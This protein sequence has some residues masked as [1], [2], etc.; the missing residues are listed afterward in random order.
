MNLTLN[1]TDL[2]RSESLLD[3]AWVAASDGRRLEVINPATGDTIGQVPDCSAEDGRA[4]VDAAQRAFGLF[5]H[6]VAR[7]RAAL[8]MRWHALVLANAEDLARLMSLEQ[9][10]PLAESR[11]EVAYGASYISWFAEEAKR[12]GGDIIPEQHANHRLLVIKQPVGVVAAITPWNFPM[13]MLARK[14]APAIAAG[15][16]VVC[17]P[18]EDTPLT[19][20]AMAALLQE[21][22]A[23]AGLVN[24][25]TTSRERA[26]GLAD[27]WL[28]DFRVRKISFTGSTPVGKHL[29]RQSADTL[30][31]L[32]LE[33]GG[34]APFIVFEDADL[35]AAVAGL[36]V[37][38]FRNAGQTCICPNRVYVHQGVYERFIDKLAARVGSLTIGPATSGAEIGPLINARA[39]DKV[40]SHLQDALGRGAKIVVGGGRHHC[41]EAPNGHFFTPTV[42]A[43]VDA[44]MRM[45]CEETFGPLVPVTPFSTDE[46][47]IALANDTPYGLAAYF[48]SR[49]IDRVWQVAEAIEAGMVAVNDGAL[50]TEIAPFGGI[51]ESGYGREGSRY[52]L[53]EY[54]NIKYIRHGN[55]AA[56]QPA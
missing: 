5:R 52:G 19:A 24:V 26:A 17:K 32:S 2:I 33:L 28:E 31:R 14:I 46:E 6:T 30:K 37:A 4:A 21:A 29:A 25:L 41:A 49:D 35:D 40:E 22:G 11:T 10:K 42:V 43:D 13:A 54:L 56:R 9:G 15:C 50:S 53:D 16:A 1:R 3:G 8:L 12:G 36:M 20:L 51:K 23:P 38:K 48:Y 34:N 44:S 45:S 7:D 27:T 39:V 18:A 47:V 55:L